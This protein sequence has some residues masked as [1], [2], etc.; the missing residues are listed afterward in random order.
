MESV[1]NLRSAEEEQNTKNNKVVGDKIRLVSAMISCYGELIPFKSINFM[2]LQRTLISKMLVSL[3]YTYDPFIL[4]SLLTFILKLINHDKV[5]TNPKLLNEI[6]S[7]TSDFLPVV[8]YLEGGSKFELIK[9]ASEK[10]SK[11]GGNSPSSQ[12]QRTQGVL[13]KVLKLFLFFVTN[14]YNKL[15]TIKRFSSDLLIT[16]ER[17]SWKFFLFTTLNNPD[18]S[19]KV[20]IVKIL[21]M[22]KTE[23]W[24]PLDTERLINYFELY[25]DKAMERSD[26]V[27]IYKLGKRS[28]IDKILL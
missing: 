8:Q 26:E 20:A 11:T 27:I 21:L 4:S 1:E 18:V 25:K 7:K 17:A 23:H 28:R 2:D 6:L 9:E 24:N 19:V 15:Q 14:S 13:K 16:L 10:Y 5:M 3:T 22:I 12:N